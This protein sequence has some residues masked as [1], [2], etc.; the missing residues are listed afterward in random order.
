[1]IKVLIIGCG[2]IGALYDIQTS[3]VNTHLKA[4]YNQKYQIFIYD[5]NIKILEKIKSIYKDI[6]VL[7]TLSDLEKYNFDC[8]SICTPTDTHINFLKL[9]INKNIPVIL[10]EKPIAYSIPEIEQIE[11]LYLKS[12]TKILVNYIRRFQDSYIFLR[13]FIKNNCINDNLA[14][15]N[16]KYYKG[17]LNNCSHAFDLISFLLNKEIN[18]SNTNILNI[19]NVYYDYFEN[20]PTI[21]LNLKI[22]NTIINVIGLTNINY[23]IFEIEFFFKNIL[24][25]ILNSGKTIKILERDINLNKNYPEKTCINDYMVNVIKYIDNLIK[26]PHIQ[27][28]FIES[29]NINKFMIKILEKMNYE[30]SFKKY[31]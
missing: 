26:Y 9:L 24:I 31:F 25:Q 17:F 15:I 21:S 22:D 11:N 1:M 30:K 5:N 18:I 16:I 13:N 20:D 10:C 14:T 8:V 2:N 6:E 19:Y 23:N 4:Y 28:N 29:T 3:E 27:D 12:N 7:F